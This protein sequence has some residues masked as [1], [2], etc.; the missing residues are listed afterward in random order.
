MNT[1]SSSAPLIDVSQLSYQ[2]GNVAVWEG[3]NFAVFSG[4]ITYLVGA[5]GSGKSTLLRC[6]SG[7]T[8]AREGSI[9]IDGQRFPSNDRSLLG[10]LF[11]VA[12]VPTF[13]D[14]LTAEE[15]LEFILKAQGRSSQISYGLELLERFGLTRFKQQLP[16]SFSRGMRTKLALAI[17][18]TLQTDILLLDEPFG[19]LDYDSRRLVCELIVKAASEDTSV[20]LSCHQEVS[21]LVPDR[22]LSI[23]D[24]SL[25]E[26]S[27]EELL[28]IWSCASD[29]PL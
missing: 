7:Q 13:Y 9:H 29:A 17:A 22:V 27:Y 18:F 16:S 24:G 10:R 1:C 11:F 20:F 28:A 12:D 4:E 21:S 6:L 8:K 26:F 25:V 2:Y 23:E 15:H 5:N 19:P 3:V 14:D